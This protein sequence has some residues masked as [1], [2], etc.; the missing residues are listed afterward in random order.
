[1]ETVMDKTE[2]GAHQGNH[3]S[4]GPGSRAERRPV[5]GYHDKVAGRVPLPILI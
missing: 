3:G 5:V 2:S 4:D 1:M